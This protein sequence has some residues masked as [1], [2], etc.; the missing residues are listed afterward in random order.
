MGKFDLYK[1]PLKAIAEGTHLFEYNLDNDYF[2]KIDS[3]EVQKGKVKASVKLKKAAAAY[4]LN[5]QLGGVVSIPCDRCLDNMEQEIAYNGRLIVKFGNDFSQESDE[6]I[7]IPEAEGEINI[8]WFLYEFIVLS[9]PV[10]HVHPSGGCNKLMSGKLKKHLTHKVADEDDYDFD[11]FD[12]S[13]DIELSEETEK[14]IDPRWDKLKNS[15]DN[16]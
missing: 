7:V 2:K 15:I 10:K 9:I 13:D 3:L 11:D 12:A 16:N 8:A 5:F 1:V 6:I 4:E 14:D